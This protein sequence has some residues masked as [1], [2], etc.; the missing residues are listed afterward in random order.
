MN[1]IDPISTNI[2]VLPTNFNL[3]VRTPE[4]VDNKVLD[5]FYVVNVYSSVH[6]HMYNTSDDDNETDDDDY[7]FVGYVE[8]D[9]NP[10]LHTSDYDAALEADNNDDMNNNDRDHLDTGHDMDISDSLF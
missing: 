7:D 4:I 8:D 2:I 5:W 1:G 6:T 10:I 3:L 9:P